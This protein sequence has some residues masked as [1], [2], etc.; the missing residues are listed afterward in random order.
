[1][2]YITVHCNLLQ[3]CLVYYTAVECIENL[4]LH[5]FTLLFLNLCVLAFSHFVVFSFLYLFLFF[6][7]CFFLIFTAGAASSTS[8]ETD[9]AR[10]TA[11]RREIEAETEAERERE[12][13]RACTL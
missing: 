8:E 5:F 10:W 12:R 3:D 13:A 11:I 1:M 6:Y 7:S 2:Q 4:L 9:Q